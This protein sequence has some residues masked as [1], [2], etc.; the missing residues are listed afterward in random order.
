MQRN[1]LR[2]NRA[3]SQMEQMK[4]DSRL[5]DIPV[6]VISALSDLRNVVAGIKQGAEDYLPK[7]FSATHLQVL[8]GRASHDER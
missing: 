4:H 6:I 3:R 5:R 8:V 1:E 7:P 2:M